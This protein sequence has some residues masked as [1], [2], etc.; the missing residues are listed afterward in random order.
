VANLILRG[1]LG[2]AVCS[3]IFTACGSSAV[4][5]KVQVSKP[6]TVW[7]CRPGLRNDPCTANLTTIIRTASGGTAEVHYQ[8]APSPKIDCFY[9]YP[10]IS[11]QTTPN[12][13]LHIDPQEV[14]IAE[15]EAS[16]FSRACRVF[17]PMYREVTT[18]TASTTVEGVAY[19]S[20]LAAWRDYLAHDNDGRGVV[21][22]GHSEGAGMVELLMAREIDRNPAIH[23][24]LVSAIITGGNLPL[25]P[26]GQPYL[27]TPA[28]TSDTQTGCVVAYDSYPSAPPGDAMFGKVPSVI[29]GLR[30][31]GVLCTNPAALAGGSGTLIPLIRTALPVSVPGSMSDG[32]FENLAPNAS[33]KGPWVELEGQYSARCVNSDGAEVLVATPQHGVAPLTSVPTPAWGLHVDDPNIALGNLVQLVQSEAAAYSS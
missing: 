29:D 31:D 16:Q 27:N 22:I 12:A 21:L 19:D 26:D 25:L 33:K 24:L 28:C 2:A 8:P 11:V 10:R 7:L 18:S 9:L 3:L 5:S 23:H 1:L 17:A 32:A 30:D 20:V 4:P 6:A 14:A 15:L 13:N